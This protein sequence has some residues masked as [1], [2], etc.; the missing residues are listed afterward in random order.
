MEEDQGFG[1]AGP[2]QKAHLLALPKRYLRTE[3]DARFFNQKLHRMILTKKLPF[4]FPLIISATL[5][6]S[7]TQ[8]KS[9]GLRP[10]NHS[11][12]AS[13]YDCQAAS[14]IFRKDKEAFDVSVSK[15]ADLI[16][17][18][19][20]ASFLEEDDFLDKIFP[21]FSAS[22]SVPTKNLAAKLAIYLNR[23]NELLALL[24][25][26][27]DKNVLITYAK[28]QNRDDLAEKIRILASH[29]SDTTTQTQ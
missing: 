4:L 10:D 21:A 19:V 14:A 28:A 3:S 16:Y 9:V 12:A 11:C 29:T 26:G 5:T 24:E 13:N 25:K 15:G 6:A 1:R 17:V 23:E 7:C 27:A 22:D 20:V 2:T 8:V 18:L